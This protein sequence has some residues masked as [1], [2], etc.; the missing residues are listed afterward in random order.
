M[1]STIGHE[2]FTCHTHLLKRLPSFL[3]VWSDIE[4]FST[5]DEDN[6]EANPLPRGFQR[7]PLVRH[8]SKATD[9]CTWRMPHVKLLLYEFTFGI[10]VLPP[11]SSKLIISHAATARL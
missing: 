8:K 1:K 7:L 2:Y 3:N 11:S 9:C 6:E 4:S 5:S 10:E